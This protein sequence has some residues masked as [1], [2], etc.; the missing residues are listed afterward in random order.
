MPFSIKHCCCNGCVVCVGNMHVSPLDGGRSLDILPAAA[1]AQGNS[2]VS[3]GSCE[4]F[5]CILIAALGLP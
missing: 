1:L 2:I 3:N 4:I 5:E